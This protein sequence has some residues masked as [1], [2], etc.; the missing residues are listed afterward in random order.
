MLLSGAA[1]ALDAIAP[2]T[3]LIET[4][5]ESGSVTLSPPGDPT[6]ASNAVKPPQIGNPLWAIPLMQLSNT[7]E[8]P[9]FSPSRRPPPPPSVNPPPVVQVVARPPPEPERPQLSLIGAV[10]SGSDGIGIFME[11]ATKSIV[12]LRMGEAHRGW[13][14]RSVQGRQATLEK[15][16]ETV[17]LA[18]P[19]RAL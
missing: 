18:F 12:R 4:A 11:N 6:S 2:A 13:T 8:R 19:P 16:S 10:V 1:E 15:D 7:R 3:T 14:L 17:V 9:I 5:G